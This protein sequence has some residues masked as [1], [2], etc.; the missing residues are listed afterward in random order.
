MGAQYEEDYIPPLPQPALSS[1]FLQSGD[2]GAPPVHLS[3]VNQQQLFTIA[4]L[5]D[6]DEGNPVVLYSS[7]DKG[8]FLPTAG[9]GRNIFSDDDF[10]SAR[11]RN[12]KFT[13]P[14]TDNADSQ[15]RA[16]AE[17]TGNI[18]SISYNNKNKLSNV[19]E[20][21]GYPLQYS[22][23][24]IVLIAFVISAWI[25]A[26]YRLL[27]GWS[28]NLRPPRDALRRK[29]FVRSIRRLK[30]SLSTSFSTRRSKS[31]DQARNHAR[32][33]ADFID[34]IEGPYAPR[35]RGLSKV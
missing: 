12:S 6:D 21:G 19:E 8:D 28:W 7:G 10:M 3:A 22:V 33:A 1:G 20:L 15:S 30:H 35:P 5:V 17:A 24:E 13:T 18:I 29:R 9:V 34:E 25:T 2:G 27:R 16:L 32:T 31:A 4:A 23:L 14:V 11:Y 26:V